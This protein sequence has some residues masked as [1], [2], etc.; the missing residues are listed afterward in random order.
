MADKIESYWI[1]RRGVLSRISDYLSD[2]R[3]ESV[4]SDKSRES[5]KD[6]SFGTSGSNQNRG[7]ANSNLAQ[8]N[9][10]LVDMAGT[11]ICSDFDFPMK[12]KGKQI[13]VCFVVMTQ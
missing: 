1:V 13:K 11:C 6:M 4:I 7:V 9:N 2:F 8:S 12:A 5:V 3:N 10:E